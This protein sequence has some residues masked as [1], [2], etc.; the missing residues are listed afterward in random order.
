VLREAAAHIGSLFRTEVPRAEQ[1]TELR[2]VVLGTC[3]VLVASRRGQQ[4]E[5]RG[6]R[7]RHQ[8]ACARPVIDSCSLVSS[9]FHEIAEVVEQ[10]PPDARGVRKDQ[11]FLEEP[12]RLVLPSV[13]AFQE[14]GQ[15]Q[16]VRVVGVCGA[17]TF[18]LAREC[19]QLLLHPE[20]AQ[21]LEL[22]RCLPG[23]RCRLP[24]LQLVD[25]AQNELA[26]PR[27]SR[28]HGCRD[29]SLGSR[30]GVVGFVRESFLVPAQ[31]P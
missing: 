30:D 2:E 1:I 28:P 13:L 19:L 26:R 4:V 17:R 7:V 14:R 24:V 31:V 5:K 3:V 25:G 27:H 15:V 22:G 23:E 11:G 29:A 18:Q 12:R 10:A 20:L 9:V 21:G 6:R 8:L 16:P